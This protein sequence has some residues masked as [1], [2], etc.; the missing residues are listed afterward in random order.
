M[1]EALRKVGYPLS[2]LRGIGARGGRRINLGMLQ[3]IGPQTCLVIEAA[4]R[5]REL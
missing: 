1:S 3:D 2:N 4:W 5:A